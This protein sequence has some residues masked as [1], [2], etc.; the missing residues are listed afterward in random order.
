MNA[1][2]VLSVILSV[3]SLILIGLVMLVDERFMF[4]AVPTVLA[5]T[6]LDHLGIEKSLRDF[7]AEGRA[8]H[9]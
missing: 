1:F 6:Y 2:S 4:V 8:R 9:D 5:A 7:L 3:V